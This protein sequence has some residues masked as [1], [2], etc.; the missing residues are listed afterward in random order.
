MTTATPEPIASLE[1]AATTHETP[2]GDGAMVW[3]DWGAGTPVVLLHGGYGSWGHWFRNIGP[4]AERFRPIAPDLPGL[5]DSAMP[6]PVRD[7][8]E[9]GTIVG[10]GLARIIGPD[11]DFH[12]AA[13]SFGAQIAGM[14]ALRFGKRVRTL[15]LAGAGGLGLGRGRRSELRRVERNMS[16]ADIWALQRENLARFLVQDPAMIDETAVWLQ[17]QNVR[18][19]RFKSIP[20]APGD[21]LARVLPD[22]SARVAGIWGE[23]DITAH[24]FVTDRRDLIRAIQ[25]EAPFEIVPG[26]GHWVQYEA[27]DAFNR[28]VLD[29]LARH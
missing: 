27:A 24:P 22:I 6:P 21:R 10:D 26:A 4:L 12:L 17:V 16:E 1:R 9:I 23:F 5:G 13:F 25:P 2:C 11:Q 29:F 18:R 8:E 19:G 14:L 15:A 7:L 3:R 20:F 28:F